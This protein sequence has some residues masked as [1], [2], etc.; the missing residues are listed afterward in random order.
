MKRTCKVRITIRNTRL[1]LQPY[2]AYKT[3]INDKVTLT[4]TIG[5]KMYNVTAVGV[6]PSNEVDTLIEELYQLISIL[7]T[8][9]ILLAI[10]DF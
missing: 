2:V 5:N 3:D 10:Y 9:D 6:I 1:V 4:G 7:P 8:K